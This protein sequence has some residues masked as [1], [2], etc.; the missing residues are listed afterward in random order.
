MRNGKLLRGRIDWI[1]SLYK[2]AVE[3]G[4]ALATSS[5]LL[6]GSPPTQCRLLQASSPILSKQSC[7]VSIHP[8][9]LFKHRL[10]VSAA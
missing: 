7:I 2:G 6:A 4:T 3:A 9:S 10:E 5:W 8:G 1:M